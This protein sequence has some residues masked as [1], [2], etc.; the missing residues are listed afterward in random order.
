MYMY[1][2]NIYMISK[3]TYVYTIY[4]NNLGEYIIHLANAV[5]ISGLTD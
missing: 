5:N 3:H 4:I 2:Y 1:A